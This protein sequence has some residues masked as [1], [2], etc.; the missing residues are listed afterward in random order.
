MYFCFYFKILKQAKAFIEISLKTSTFFILTMDNC[1][2]I[3]NN[4]LIKTNEANILTKL[5]KYFENNELWL[6]VIINF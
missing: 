5:L 4:I 6:Y 1:I 2:A 3:G